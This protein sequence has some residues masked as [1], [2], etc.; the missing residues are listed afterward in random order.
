VSGASGAEGVKIAVLVVELY[1]VTPGRIPV[2]LLTVI[3]S[4]RLAGSTSWL[5][6]RVMGLPRG[7]SVALLAGLVDTTAK[8]VDDIV[9]KEA[10]VPFAVPVELEAAA[11]W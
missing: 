3:A 7:T 1:D 10:I 11:R 4:T 2:P 9:V 6:V 8:A 5:K